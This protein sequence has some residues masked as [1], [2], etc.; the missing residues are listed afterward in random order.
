MN[1]SFKLSHMLNGMVKA[2][3]CMTEQEDHIND[4]EA[5]IEDLES[6]NENK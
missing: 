1:Y 3:E 6:Q 5:R 2:L 4:L